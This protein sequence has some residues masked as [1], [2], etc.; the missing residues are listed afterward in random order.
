MNHKLTQQIVKH[1]FSNLKIID[2]DLVKEDS[3]SITD[4]E[5]SLPET[6]SFENDDDGII[7]NHLWGCQFS[8]ENKNLKI[9]VCDTSIDK[10]NEEFCAVI[11]LDNTPMYGLYLDMSDDWGVDA[12]IACSI[13]GSEWAKCSTYLEATFLAAMEQLKNHIVFPNICDEYRE[14]YKAILTF[15]DYYNTSNRV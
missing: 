1:V 9:L 13:T 7:Q 14:E 5:F 8:V 2:S 11:H 15:L 12:L 3:L 10:K 6:I 4:R